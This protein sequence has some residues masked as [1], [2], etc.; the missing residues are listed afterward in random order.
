MG[1]GGLG[2]VVSAMSRMT[3]GRLHIDYEQGKWGV[4]VLGAIR[5][6]IGA[7]FGSV[8]WIVLAADSSP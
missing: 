6:M 4:R 2:A 1:C 8:L 7:V 5:P 3:S